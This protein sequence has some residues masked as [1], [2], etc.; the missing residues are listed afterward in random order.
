MSTLFNFNSYLMHYERLIYLNGLFLNG[1]DFLEEIVLPFVI[2]SD[3]GNF[4]S[5]ILI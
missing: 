3:H 5:I 1:N 2:L 4:K